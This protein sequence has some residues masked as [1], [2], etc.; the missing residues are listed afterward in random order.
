[1]PG[2]KQLVQEIHRRSLWQVVGIY[3][4][5][6]WIALQIVDVLQQNFGLPEWFPAFALGLLVLGLPVVLATAFVQEGMGSRLREDDASNDQVGQAVGAGAAAEHSGSAGL[7]TWRNAMLGGGAA[8]ALWGI[9]AAG[10][11]VFGGSDVATA[12]TQGS[13]GM[14]A[15]GT[16]QATAD[17]RSIAVLPFATRSDMQTDEYFSEGMHDDLLTQLSKI[18]SLTVISRTSVMQYAGTTKT[19]REI[20][21]ELGVATVMEGGIQRAGDRVRVNV[22]LIEATS[23]RHIWAETYDEE[24]SAA[25]V[26][27]IQ[28][29]LATKIAG[30]LRATLSPE[31]AQRI[32][33]VPTQSIEAYELYTRARYAWET[34]GSFGNDLS[35]VQALFERAIEADS[36]FAPAWM[37]L[38]NTYL[39]AWN[40]QRMSP[41]EAGPAA[42]A[43]VERALDLDPALAEAHVTRARLLQF[44]GQDEQAE[45]AVLRALELNPGSAMAHGRYGQILEQDG[46]YEEA[47]RQTR[48]A[49]ELD[50]LSI[51]NRNL[52][53]DR[54]FYARD[55]AASIEVS[56]KVIEMEPGD[57]YAWYNLGWA[58]ATGG[59]A[60][61]AIVAFRES[62][63]LAGE[64]EGSALLG[65]A[66]AFARAGQRDSTLVYLEGASPSSYDISIALF[67]LGDAD[68]AFAALETAL[69]ADGS[70]IRRLDRDPSADRMR[71]DPRYGELAD[72]LGSN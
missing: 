66:Y 6:A 18:D 16:P 4:V 61:E 45:D 63:S 24:L 65:L 30:A 15:D 43:A 69:E 7:L 68:E 27:A 72:R 29:D 2:L 53:S 31:V 39:S 38:A 19:I 59:S 44:E 70:Q 50:P 10:W 48:R 51:A 8:L 62:A 23:D 13:A 14:S 26:F 32:E 12:P 11:M 56:K 22:Q 49:V 28:S 17:L 46:R 41:E 20:A 40:W 71:A 1:M 35:E 64:N 34:R 47:V 60:T 55:F 58:A 33:S 9:I 57:W 42:R 3:L 37:G 5:G 54:L 36:T 67:E 52:L 25:N 21:G